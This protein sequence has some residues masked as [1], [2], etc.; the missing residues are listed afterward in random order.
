MGIQLYHV[1]GGLTT[2]PYNTASEYIS[3]AWP[4]SYMEAYPA[5]PEQSTRGGSSPRSQVREWDSEW[6]LK[7]G[8]RTPIGVRVGALPSEAPE[9]TEV[10]KDEGLSPRKKSKARGRSQHWWFQQ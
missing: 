7:G 3:Y 9:V 10:T 2:T 1:F 6:G 8:V 5:N 4:A